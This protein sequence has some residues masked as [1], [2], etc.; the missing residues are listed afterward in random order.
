MLLQY[1][2]TVLIA[3]QS[4]HDTSSS[5]TQTYVET[6][7]FASYQAL[8]LTIVKQSKQ[9]AV[10]V[11]GARSICLT[12]LHVIAS[13]SEPIHSGRLKEPSLVIIVKWSIHGVGPAGAK[14]PHGSRRPYWAHLRVLG[15]HYILDPC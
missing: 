2:M 10:L 15:I 7:V 12:E 5:A 4:F 3:V 6:V 9:V 14:C 13:N 11:K 1:A 8:A